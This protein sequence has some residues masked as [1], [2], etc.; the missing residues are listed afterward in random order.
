MAV[1]ER[2]V[3]ASPEQVFAVLA[4]GWTYSDWVVGTNHIRKVDASWPQPGSRLYV[5]SGIWPADLKGHSEVL[6][7][8]RPHRLVIRPKL[9]PFGELTV[10]I[11]IRA[12]A[13]GVSVVTIAEDVKE[14]P[15]HW[16]RTKLSDLV[17]HARNIESLRRLADLAE[18]RPRSPLGAGSHAST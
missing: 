8:D 12:A 18:H 7:C 16:V 17:L 15:M 13:D 14:G 10:D 11:R 9:W 1:V 4:D 2:E 6:E 3:A 5:Q